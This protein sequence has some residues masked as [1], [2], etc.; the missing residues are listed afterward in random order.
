LGAAL[1]ASVRSNLPSPKE[2]PMAHDTRF[3]IQYPTGDLLELYVHKYKEDPVWVTEY[4][5]SG[6]VIAGP[7]DRDT[8]AEVLRDARRAGL[9]ITREVY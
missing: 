3:T 5:P 7:D 1:L 6:P 8:C 4:R 2:Y 9:P